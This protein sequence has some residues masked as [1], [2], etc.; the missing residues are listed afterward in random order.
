MFPL[1]LENVEKSFYEKNNLEKKVLNKINIKIN[2]GDIFGLVG[3]N[4]IGKTTMIKSILDFLKLDNGNIF[5]FGTNNIDS[6]SR[7][8]ICYLPEKFLPSPYL[9]GYE[10]LS[11]S[12]SYFDKKLDINKAK[13]MAEKI[14][15]NP[16]CLD[17]II[18]KYSKGMGQK[19]GLLSC[20][21]SEAKLLI[22]DEPMTGL[23]PRSRVMLKEVLKNYVSDG[24]SI[25][26]SSHILEDV[27]EICNVMAVLH[28]G[29]I[30]F[31]GAPMEFKGKYEEK[32][33]EKS[34]LKCIK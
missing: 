29:E 23:D 34:F 20:I 25:F 7:K 22:L 16:N 13:E 3:L 9:S 33:I 4:G 31:C 24:K 32:N 6:K 11:L 5:I 19:L 18:I 10:F 26:F 30:K 15:L 28:N 27:E 1:V 21:L 8:N 14:D 12:L 17:K 2:S